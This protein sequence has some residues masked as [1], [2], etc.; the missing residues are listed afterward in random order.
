MV[1][2]HGVDVSIQQN[3]GWSYPQKPP[4]DP[5]EK[6][7]EMTQDMKTVTSQE[8]NLVYAAVRQ[9]LMD[10]KLDSAQAGTAL[11]SPFSD[12]LKN[13][14]T[15]V[16]KPNLV[17]NT[18]DPANQFTVVTHGSVIRPIVDYAWKAVGP[19]GKIIIGDA[20]QAEADF[21]LITERNGLKEMIN[22]LQARG[23]NV[24]LHDFRCIKVVME[25]G[26]WVGEQENAR[27]SAEGG[28]TVNLGEKSQFY[29]TDG[30]N[31]RYHG[32]G[33]D[34]TVTRSHH[35][36]NIHEYKIA[37]QV[38]TADAVI[39]V[40][41][42]KTH[43][44]AGITCC[45]KNLV[46]INVD[47]NYLPHFTIGPK[48]IAG[49]EMPE[50]TGVN[51]VKTRVMRTVRDFVLDKHWRSTGKVIACT[52]RCLSK[53]KDK[54]KNLAESTTRQVSGSPVFMGAWPGNETIVKMILDLNRAFLYAD[55][56]GVV[57]KHPVRK[58][59]YVV[60]GII[61]GDRNG[62]MEPNPVKAGLVGAVYNALGVDVALLQLF[63]I[64]PEAIPLYREA[65]KH[66]EWLIPKNQSLDGEVYLNGESWNREK[67]ASI[68]LL[69]PD[70]WCF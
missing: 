7:P 10:C 26:I 29:R 32:G 5:S 15:V 62:P 53:E 18:K 23:V 70:N 60:D 52:L 51:L 27:Y 57:Q 31:P 3:E 13:G 54:N 40:P 33:Y 20:P 38:L 11:W 45:L 12:F 25:N 44:K 19:T 69:P 37:R 55:S 65:M 58:V 28:I 6:Y 49:D 59:F 68:R 46:G 1:Y 39:S 9:C 48:N 43:K 30:I 14:D 2:S 42:M 8:E 24:E 64:D 17:L 67:T 66:T 36:D 47:K 35:H 34:S 16:I 61:V 21:E 4:F 41:K 50:I 22:C 63:G 56:D